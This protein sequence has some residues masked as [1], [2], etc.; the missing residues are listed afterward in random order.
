MN[1]AWRDFL[2]EMDEREE[3]EEEIDRTLKADTF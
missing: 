2:L 3:I 1:R